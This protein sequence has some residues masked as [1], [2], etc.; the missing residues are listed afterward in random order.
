[1]SAK[2]FYFGC[3]DQP[4]HYMHSPGMKVQWGFCRNNPWGYSIDGGLLKGHKERF[5]LTHKDG[6]TALSFV[7]NT[8]DK[9]PGSNSSFLAEGTFTLD[10]MF[11]LARKNFPHIAARIKLFGPSGGVVG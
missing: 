3:N 4:G 2:V 6:W 5:V 11:E 1:M 7:D 9:R 10:E 8:V